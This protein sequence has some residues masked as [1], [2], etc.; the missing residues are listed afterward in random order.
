MNEASQR[1]HRQEF[2]RGES[3]GGIRPNL[4]AGTLHHDDLLQLPAGDRAFAVDDQL[5]V[6]EGRSPLAGNPIEP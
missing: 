2:S 3:L 1:R 6:G 4:A 5:C